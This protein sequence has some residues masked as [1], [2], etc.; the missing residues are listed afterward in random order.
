MLIDKFNYQ[1]PYLGLVGGVLV[2]RPA[3]YAETNGFSNSFWGKG[4]ED[5]DFNNFA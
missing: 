4:D 5:D 3:F 2:I 1:L